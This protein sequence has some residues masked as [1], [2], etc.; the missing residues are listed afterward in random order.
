MI[1]LLI[2][3]NE[4]FVVESLLDLFS[5]PCGLE[6]EVSGAYSAAEALRALER[7]KFDIVL[8]DIRMPGMDGLA[9]HKE[10]V[11]QWPWCKV[12]FLTGY[13]DF[14][15]IQQVMRNGG[16]DYL[17]KSEGYDAV[18][19]AVRK[20]AAQLFAAVEAEQLLQK[21]RRQQQEARPLLRNMYMLELLQ[22]DPAAQRK[23]K[24]EAKFQELQLP[25]DSGDQVLLVLGRVDDWREEHSATDVELMLY[26]IQNIAEEYLG[27]S[28][29]CCTVKLEHNKLLWCIQPAAGEGDR[30]KHAV[31][32]AHGMLETI[33][34]ACK[35]HLKLILSFAAAADGCG[36]ESAPEQLHALKRQLGRGLGIGKE[37]ILIDP[38]PGDAFAPAVRLQSHEA[39]RQLDKMSALGAYL[40]NG[41]REHFFAEW[42]RMMA[43][44]PAQGSHAAQAVRPAH[45]AQA[46]RAAQ[47]AH[48]AQ[49]ARATQA[50]HGAQAARAPHAPQASQAPYASQTE[51]GRADE[52]LQLELYFALVALFL[53]YLNRWGL[54]DELGSAIDLGLLVRYEAHRSWRE[55]ENY[56]FR[57]AELL[58]EQKQADQLHSEDDLIK[59]VQLYVE[60]NLAGDLSLTAIG[61]MVGYNP[62]YLTRLYK[63]MTGEGLTEHIAA[64][65]LAKAQKLLGQT[66][67]VIQDISRAVG[68]LSEQSFYRFFKKAAQLT[69]Q[70]YRDQWKL[71]NSANG[72]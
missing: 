28:A 67:M 32:F 39:R 3:D 57:L 55:R 29:V 12:I 26:A 9:L 51:L 10:I 53:G 4:R 5:R 15:Y 19:Q 18:L 71:S 7:A 59:R 48:G 23:R 38:P 52:Q 16:V 43:L 64:A 54:H 27:K 36:W 46:A 45:G 63:R 1:R 21:A 49:T 47:A 68:F 56:L 37:L 30:W 34:A 65:R 44:V 17:L 14:E 2:V 13:D 22:G 70:E 31:R 41:Q 58:F 40:E 50:A 35:Q 11:R 62:Y 25:L 60:H 72:K 42:A 6:L 61:E 33:Q 66:T 24:Q 8:S 69:P 20:A